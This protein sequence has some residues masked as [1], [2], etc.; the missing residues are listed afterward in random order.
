[1]YLS[2]NIFQYFLHSL[3]KLKRICV[4]GHAN[5]KATNFLRVLEIKENYRKHKIMM[6]DSLL[7]KIWKISYGLFSSLNPIFSHFNSILNDLKIDGWSNQGFTKTSLY[8]WNKDAMIK[9]FKLEILIYF[10][11][12]VTKHWTPYTKHPI[13]S[14]FFYQIEQFFWCCK[15]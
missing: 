7:Q 15:H 12:I 3:S 11:A 10:N 9:I 2:S 1:M 14:P 13:Y 4:I 5:W 8:S 6:I